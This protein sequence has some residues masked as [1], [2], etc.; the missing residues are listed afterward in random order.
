MGVGTAQAAVRSSRGCRSCAGDGPDDRAADRV[1]PDEPS[2][3]IVGAQRCGTTSMYK[4]LR[5]HPMVLPAVLHK[6]VHY[7]DTDYGHGPGWYRGHFP[8]RATAP[9]GPRRRR[10]AADHR[11]VEP[12]L[13]VPPAGRP[14][15]SPPTC[16]ASADRAAA[17]PGR[18]GLLGATRTRPPAASRPS[19]SSGRS[20]W[21]RSGWPARRARCSPTRLRQPPHQHHAYLTR[22]RYVD[23]LRA[24][25]GAVRAR[26]ACTWSTA[27]DFF[28]DPEPVFAEVLDFLGSARR[29]RRVFEQHNARP[30]SP[31]PDSV[32]AR[33]EDQLADSDSELETWLGAPPSWRA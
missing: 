27:S 23:Q 1:G 11:R 25:G 30:R 15:G 14:T 9:R 8:L 26:P 33:L 32:R 13:H 6:G 29:R 10:T 21:S 20:S 18:A 17:R 16:P 19:R 22:G 24:A 4:T 12:V 2:F 5:Q 28:T 31:M 3:L 7:F